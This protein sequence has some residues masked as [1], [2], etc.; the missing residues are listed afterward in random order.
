LK[1]EASP[2]AIDAIQEACT[3][4]RAAPKRQ[5]R[6]SVCSFAIQENETA[7]IASKEKIENK[8]LDAE[9]AASSSPRLSP[10]ATQGV[11]KWRRRA[12]ICCGSLLEGGLAA[13]AEKESSGL[14]AFAAWSD[15]P[16]LLV[17][18]K[19]FSSTVKNQSADKATPTLDPKSP[20]AEVSPP[21][22]HSLTF[23]DV[24]ERKPGDAGKMLAD[25]SGRFVN[26]VLRVGSLAARLGSLVGESHRTG[27]VVNHIA[28]VAEKMKY[29]PDAFT[30]ECNVKRLALLSHL[31]GVVNFRLG[32]WLHL[33]DPQNVGKPSKPRKNDKTRA[34]DLLPEMNF[35]LT[36]T[37]MLTSAIIPILQRFVCCDTRPSWS[38][39]RS[40]RAPYEETDVHSPGGIF[41][42]LEQMLQDAQALLQIA[43]DACRYAL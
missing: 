11:G 20:D 2:F 12:S 13:F 19:A 37:E 8:Q 36:R 15:A 6:S 26:I 41:A 3:E 33:L 43:S 10:K 9:L 23:E 27:Q 17:Q 32:K 24:V 40:R 29:N 28:R 25:N 14:A 35:A 5:R 18:R 42:H 34:A 38:H 16:T 7:R 30:S 39:D 4:A 1:K 22:R 31:Q 21:K